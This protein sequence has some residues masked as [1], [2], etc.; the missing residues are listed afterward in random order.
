MI[1]AYTKCGVALAVVGAICSMPIS[2]QPIAFNNSDT[3]DV[4]FPDMNRA[5]L[6]SGAIM[7]PDHVR[8]MGLG[9]TKNQVRSIIQYPH[10]SE[11]LFGPNQWDYIFNFKKPDGSYLTCQYQVHFNEEG[12]TIGTYW[13]SRECVQFLNPKPMINQTSPITVSADG[14]FAF[15]RSGWNDLQPSGRENLANIANQIKRSFSTVRSINVIGH[16]DRIGSAESNAN[17]SLERANTVRAYF[18]SQGIDGRIIHTQGMGSIKPVTFCEGA[19]SPAV[20]ACLMPNRR[21]EIS[22]VGDN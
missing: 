21:I 15:G 17:L 3:K 7:D 11:G 4:V 2:A 1:N 20:I 16:T 6:K 5:W 22:V 12:K 13:N 8:S 10:F 9:L 14:L 19:K 18:V